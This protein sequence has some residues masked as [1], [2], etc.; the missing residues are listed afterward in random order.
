[1]GVYF[2]ISLSASLLVSWLKKRTV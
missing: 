1:G 2:V